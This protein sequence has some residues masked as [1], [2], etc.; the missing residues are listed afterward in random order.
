LG[1]L[2][3]I[4]SVGAHDRLGEIFCLKILAHLR[5]QFCPVVVAVTRVDSLVP[6]DGKQL[7]ALSDEMR[8]TLRSRS[9]RPNFFNSV[10]AWRAQRRPAEMR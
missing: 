9:G 6:D 4:L 3:A 5:N 7:R 8:S 10:R 2:G 1:E